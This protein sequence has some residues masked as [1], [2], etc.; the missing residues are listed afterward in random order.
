MDVL[1]SGLD[2]ERVTLKHRR[3]LA[4]GSD[5][6]GCELLGDAQVEVVLASRTESAP[7]GRWPV[8]AIEHLHTARGNN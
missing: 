1:H 3:G 2:D 5:H 4:R 8:H 6:V 7:I